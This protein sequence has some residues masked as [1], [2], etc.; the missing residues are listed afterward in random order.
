MAALFPG[1]KMVE[2]FEPLVD[3]ERAYLRNS[4]VPEHNALNMRARV[5][6][7]RGTYERIVDVIE[8]YGLDAFLAAQDG[9][10]DYVERVVRSRLREIPDG[11][12]YAKCYHDHD[13]N[14]NN[15]Y[16]LCCRIIKLGERLVVDLTGTAPQAI[17]SINCA[18]PAAEGSI[19]GVILTFL[20]Y[21]LP[22]SIGAL[23]NIVEVTSEPGTLNN[24]L[25]PAA[26]SMASTMGTLST[27]DVVAHAFAK[28]LLASPRYC[29]ESQ[30]SW[31][32]GINGSLL[33]AANPPH[34]PAVGAI[35]DFVSGGGGARTFT[36]GIDAGGIFHSMA[37]QGTNS[38][39]VESRVPALQIYR[40]QQRDAAGPGTYRGG[41]PVEFATIPHKL[42]V[43]PAGLNTI[44]S[45]ISV[46]AGRGLAGGAPGAAASTVVLRDSNIRELF[47]RG[48]IPLSADEIECAETQLVDAKSFIAVD[49]SDVVIG[50][51]PSGA[52]YGDPLRRD[53]ARTAADVRDDLVSEEHALSVYGVVVRGGEVDEAATERARQRV[54]DARL[55]EGR[56]DLPAEA[57]AVLTGGT[58]LH[59]VSD[60]VEAVE[61]DG[62][63]S[64]RC[65]VCHYRFG[66]YDHDHK[67]SALM[68]EL[69]LTA[70]SSR[71]G[72]CLERFVAREY[73][74]P[75]CGTAV[76]V[77]VQDSD[78]PFIE[79]SRFYPR[80]AAG[81]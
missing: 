60:T 68:R 52:G 46:P 41:A 25:S 64:L 34:E 31:T 59:P 4:R 21:D 6:A 58:V 5:A 65:T 33:I 51:L 20:C 2:N 7:L 36:D 78:E 49:E 1:I 70:I 67:R 50:V 62:Q 8:Q 47:T 75:G 69:P 3:V 26:M 32:P 76:A 54:R 37:S 10:I 72:R 19:M 66:S 35:V 61:V 48:R 39:T 12:W 45:G 56:A 63:R 24:A 43:R 40:R 18:L 11:E 57:A 81:P 42:P 55:T 77:D 38:E 53:P 9:I 80:G 71:N 23:R 15:V 79:E 27:Q 29:K 30:A 28:M 16:P 14:E 44:S 73:S 22:W 17:G 13:G 74:C